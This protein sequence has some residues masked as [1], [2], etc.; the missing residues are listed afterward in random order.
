M[1]KILA[2]LLLCSC[3]ATPAEV[4]KEPTTSLATT[5]TTQ[6]VPVPTTSQSQIAASVPKES[7]SIELL[8]ENALRQDNPCPEWFDEAQDAGWPLELWP[9][10]S[11]VIWRESRC[12]VE[13]W[14]KEDPFGGS[15]GLM[16]INQFWC[17][18]SQYTAHG[19][20]QDQ[21]ILDHCLELHDPAINLEASLAIFT[22]STLKNKNGWNPWSMRAD[23][24][25]P[26]VE[27]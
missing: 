6:V 17:K 19:W 2:A 18:P 25:P 1:R 12:S 26:A 3:T 13:A 24:D 16:Q 22:Y 10:Q 8:V 7:V 11:Y 20:L 21:G 27:S 9:Q 15:R 14:N 23:F 4:V 5:K